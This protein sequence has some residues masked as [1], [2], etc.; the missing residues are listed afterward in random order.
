MIE[1]VNPFSKNDPVLLLFIMMFSVISP[2]I[3]VLLNGK[4]NDHKQVDSI[5]INDQKES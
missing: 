1:M 5:C 3:Y 4:K 2:I